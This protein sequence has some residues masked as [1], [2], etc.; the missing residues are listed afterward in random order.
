MQIDRTKPYARLVIRGDER[1][2]VTIDEIG[3]FLYD[4]ATLYE[5]IRLAVD[6]KYDDFKFSRFSLYRNGRPIKPKDDIYIESLKHSSPLELI[7][8]IALPTGLALAAA[9][10][11]VQLIDKV[12]NLP[13]NRKKLILDTRN[14][15]LDVEK[16]QLEIA[17]LRK[18]ALLTDEDFEKYVLSKDQSEQ[19]FDQRKAVDP[20]R[21]AVKRLRK[22]SI[23]IE[24]LELEVIDPESD[25]RSLKGLYD[26]LDVRNQ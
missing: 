13:L 3:L 9:W 4:F 5:L 25:A 14:S 24:E 19:M 18:D 21:T 11:F 12:Y 7:A 8:Q 26:W 23:K 16:K 15:E 2:Q 10:T 17:A 22:S 20:I 6:P 1:D